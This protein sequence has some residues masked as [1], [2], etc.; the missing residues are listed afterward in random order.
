MNGY[1]NSAWYLGVLKE[2]IL[3][4]LNELGEG[5]R[6]QQDGTNAHTAEVLMNWFQEEEI[7]VLP[8]PAKSPDV[9]L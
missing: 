3:P 1:I 2:R 9:N 5:F 8:L 6:F 4:F 7:E